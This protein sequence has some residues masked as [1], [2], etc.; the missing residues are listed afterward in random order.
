MLIRS[1]ILL[2][3]NILTSIIEQPKRTEVT[4]VTHCTYPLDHTM[5]SGEIGVNDAVDFVKDI[6][7]LSTQYC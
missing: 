7:A 1:D 4:A 5:V 3:V 2:S 6:L